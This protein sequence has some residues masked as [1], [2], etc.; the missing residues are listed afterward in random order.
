MR[1]LIAAT[2]E[3]TVDKVSEARKCL[4]DAL[5]NGKELIGRGEGAALCV[6]GH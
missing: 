5:D 4:A 2:A 3:V 1:A 6:L